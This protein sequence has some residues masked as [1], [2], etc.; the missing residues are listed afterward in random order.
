MVPNI[1]G[2]SVAESN[3]FFFLSQ[4]MS[5]MGWMVGRGTLLIDVSQ[6]C[7]PIKIPFSCIATVSMCSD[8]VLP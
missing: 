8:H 5:G 1:L 7:K 4:F 6:R 3:N 2:I